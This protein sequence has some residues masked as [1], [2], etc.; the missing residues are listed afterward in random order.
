ME[1][2][3]TV[4][5]RQEDGV[6]VVKVET[7]DTGDDHEEEEDVTDRIIQEKLQIRQQQHRKN[8]APLKS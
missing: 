2:V 7:D 5:N 6:K 8:A 4:A 1:A 3:E